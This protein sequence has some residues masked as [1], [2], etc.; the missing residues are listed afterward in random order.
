MKRL[1][2]SWRVLVAGMLGIG[3]MLLAGCVT[4]PP[5]K[6]PS[7]AVLLDNPDGTTGAITITGSR[8]QVLITRS[9]FGATLDG[10]SQPCIFDQTQLDA[11]FGEVLGARPILP[12]TFVLYF[13]GTSTTLTAESKAL[14]SK[15]LAA[16]ANRPVPDIS[17]TGHTD[18]LGSVA[19]NERLGLDRAQL[20]AKII[21]DAKLQVIEVSVVSSGEADLA[22]KTPD[23]TP[24]PRNRRVEI[25][26]R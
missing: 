10:S 13:E 8:G 15:V 22:V 24:E 23:E 16:I 1:H 4:R 20:I 19:S 26:I 3:A 2:L 14:V 25:S 17:I 6:P 21:A 18:T 11:D 7:Y 9:R 12:V 5:P